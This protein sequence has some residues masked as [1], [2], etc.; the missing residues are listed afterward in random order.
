VHLL[1]AD[2]TGPEAMNNSVVKT[3]TGVALAFVWHFSEAL[4]WDIDYMR[5][6]FR[7]YKGEKQ[8]VNFINSGV[9]LKW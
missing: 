1:D 3:Q 9:T 6:M 2:K 5:A 7:W 4:H 8:D